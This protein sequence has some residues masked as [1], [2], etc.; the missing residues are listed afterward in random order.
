MPKPKKLKLIRSV[1]FEEMYFEDNSFIYD[2]EI[3]NRTL[4]SETHRNYYVTLRCYSPLRT[5]GYKPS[6]DLNSAYV[7]IEMKDNWAC[8]GVMYG[9]RVKS[10]S[11]FG[12]LD[13]D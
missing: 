4:Q 2:T 5:S 6:A 9:Q 8:S 13:Q 11:V 3:C 12:F 10:P 1:Q 7:Q